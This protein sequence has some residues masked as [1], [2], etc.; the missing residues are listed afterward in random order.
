MSED[1][2]AIFKILKDAI[3]DPSKEKIDDFITWS[4]EKYVNEENLSY[5]IENDLDI[6]TLALNHYGMSHSKTITPIF[7][8]TMKMYW[9]EVE[10]YLINVEKVFSI[11]SKKPEIK[12]ILD[13]EK[14]RSYLNRCCKETYD[15]LYDFVWKES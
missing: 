13:T 6:V 4:L 15:K 12:E 9:G 11:L 1:E 3:L 7:K 5:S 10:S 2:V 14:G 8:I